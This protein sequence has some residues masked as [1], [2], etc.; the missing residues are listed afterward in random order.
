MFC[1]RNP[2]LWNV[3]LIKVNVSQDSGKYVIP[4]CWIIEYKKRKY[5]IF[6]GDLG[7]VMLIIE[8]LSLISHTKD[9][10]FEI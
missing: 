3:R 4:I 5:C 7:N 8:S 9:E 1:Q 10:V 6:A 2:S